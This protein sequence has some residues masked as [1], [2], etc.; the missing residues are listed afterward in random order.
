MSL[1]KTKLSILQTQLS[2]AWQIQTADLVYS[3]SANSSQYSLGP[4]SSHIEQSLAGRFGHHHHLPEDHQE[5]DQDPCEEV[6]QRD[7]LVT[8]MWLQI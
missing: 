5:P 2:A 1:L 6:R 4:P 8:M 7:K 3:Q